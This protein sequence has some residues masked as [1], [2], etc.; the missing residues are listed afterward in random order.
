MDIL[1]RYFLTKYLHLN[2]VVKFEP[3]VHPKVVEI[4]I[5]VPFG[6]IAAK[7]WG[8]R[9]V[10][11]VLCVHGWQDNAAT[12]DA[13][14]PLL[15]NHVG[16]LAVDLP[17][18]GLSSQI[19]NGMVYTQ[20][21][22]IYILNYII[23]Q[24]GWNSVSLMGHSMG[25][26]TCFILAA[27]FPE[28]VDMVIALD[29]LQPRVVSHEMVTLYL[30]GLEKMRFGE[31][32][33]ANGQQ[34]PTHTFEELIEKMN[35]QTFLSVTRSSAIYLLAR[36]VKESNTEPGRFYFTRDYRLKFTEFT[37][38]SPEINDS[39]ATSIECPFLFVKALQSPYYDSKMYMDAVLNVMMDKS[40]F[41]MTTVDGGHHV[42]LNNPELVSGAV[43]KFML[44]HKPSNDNQRV[45]GS[46]L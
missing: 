36:A 26:I 33:V 43:V 3:I 16:Y 29:A 27:T 31:L 20:I 28:R 4:T 18:H 42:H 35:S 24:F 9:D 23:R 10:R 17:G 15:P 40:N 32:R 6:H 13:L 14:I 22:D 30:S 37:M 19:P 21:N 8:R 25:A 5:K 1:E 2:P 11:P 46:K 45:F 7:W 39:L 41:S 44:N 34:P 38:Y 12:F